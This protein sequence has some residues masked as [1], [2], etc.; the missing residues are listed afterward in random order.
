MPRSTIIPT[1]STP[2]LGESR[3]EKRT[4][5]SESAVRTMQTTTVFC[6][7]TQYRYLFCN[8][9]HREASRKSW[10]AEIHM[11]SSMLA[12]I[13]SLEERKLVQTL[14]DG[15]LA[16]KTVVAANRFGETDNIWESVCSPMFNSEGKISGVSVTSADVTEQRRLEDA[17]LQKK[18]SYQYL[19]D[20]M[21]EPFLICE[22]IRDEQGVPCNYR[23][24]EANKAYEAQ[25]GI[26]V[27][28]IIGRT[29]LE[30][31]P[32]LDVSWIKIYGDV[33]LTHVPH[34]F[35]LYNHSSR[36]YYE[37]S[38]FSLHNGQFARVFKDITDQKQSEFA[39]KTS[40][41]FARFGKQI[42]EREKEMAHL[43]RLNTMGEM[44]TGLAHELNQPLA[45]I[46]TYA[47][48]ALRM[49]NAELTQPE[50]LQG[51]ITAVCQ[52]AVR[53]SEIIRHLRRLVK[54]QTVGRVV[55]DIN[56]L[57]ESVAELLTGDL[58][59]RDVDLQLKLAKSLP[60]VTVDDVQIEQVMIN[61]LR[62][63]LEA[64][65]GFEEAKRE[66][67][68]KTILVNHKYIQV[69]VT[70]NGAGIEPGA[71]SQIFDAFYSTKG[72][73]GMGMGLSISRS[74]VEAHG[75]RLWANSEPG[76]GSTLSFSLPVQMLK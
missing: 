9:A 47:D 29:V 30:T 65:P 14:L 58:Q 76:Q 15:A 51:I 62:N 70:D 26:N 37:V 40:E 33:A 22:I 41:E 69:E 38:V 57:I 4:A 75:G 59:S 11:G 18:D 64:D 43:D 68:I 24:L 19:F 10:G 32:D 72:E 27:T 39:L 12:I 23:I 34:S 8:D 13:A 56:H 50:K 44:A 52:Q 73:P 71:S 1:E 54:K 3:G 48:V 25:M 36:R 53:A 55:T 31:V 16:G 67:T 2:K 61:L 7:D 46:T 21:T 35:E 45:A 17:L 49:V 20:N 5:A 63:A 42:R 74:I 28:N 6:L 60:S 66:V